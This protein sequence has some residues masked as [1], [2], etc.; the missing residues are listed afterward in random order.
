MGWV[1]V[2]WVV[3]DI[4]GRVYAPTPPR[5]VGHDGQVSVIDGQSK[6]ANIRSLSTKLHVYG[7]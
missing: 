4:G 2:G 7:F 5:S 1:V 3:E 6:S